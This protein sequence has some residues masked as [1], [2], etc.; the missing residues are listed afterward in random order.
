MVSAPAGEPAPGGDPRLGERVGDFLIEAPIADGGV[1]RV[2]LARHVSSGAEVAVKVLRDE[3]ASEPVAIE[4]FRREFETAFGLVHPHIVKA[5]EFGR[6]EDGSNFMIMELLGGEP[7]SALLAREGALEPERA[8][9]FVCQIAA[10]LEHA[11]SFGVIHRDLKPENIFLSASDD[12][13]RVQLLDFGSVK[14]QLEMGPKLTAYGMTL[15]SPSYMAPEQAEGLGDLDQRADVFAL[16]AVTY[17]MLTGEVAFDG[18]DAGTVLAKILRGRPTPM[19]ERDPSLPLGID[20]VIA[21]G[22]M[23]DKARRTGSARELAEAL[24]RV[25]GLEPDVERYGSLPLAAWPRLRP[26]QS[27]PGREAAAGG[28]AHAGGSPGPGRLGR[29]ALMSLGGAALAS[30]ALAYLLT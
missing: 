30:A 28:G 19:R 15:G 1:A 21:A 10:A 24:L 12:G 23:R 5:R 7:L 27:V 26:A 18:V 11:H 3:A 16:A 14:L 17:E 9:R 29:W 13:A 8:L 2:Y 25:F 22:L 4:R 20:V 6:A